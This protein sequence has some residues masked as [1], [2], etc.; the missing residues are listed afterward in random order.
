TSINQ[1]LTQLLT[2]NDLW[3]SDKQKYTSRFTLKSRTYSDYDEIMNFF[4]NIYSIELCFKQF[5]QALTYHYQYHFEYS[6]TESKLIQTLFPRLIELVEQSHI[7]EHRLKL[8]RE[9]FREIIQY[10]IELFQRMIDEL[11][12]KFD[13]YGPYKINN[14]LNQIFLLVK[15]YE[16]EIN[17]IEQR[18]IELIN[19]MKLFHIPLINYPNL[20]RIQKEINGLNILFNIYDEFKRNK[21]LWSNILWTELNINDLIIN[22]DLFIKNFR[23]LSLDIKTTI[24]GHT[25]EQYLTGYLI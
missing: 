24:V 6:Q 13:K 8:I 20:I 23:R 12:D 21:K 5:H 14:D 16:K 7:I 2:Y 1:T 25:V 3:K 18:K 4:S 11:V 10:D 15:Q 22:V 17:N 19:I 9:R